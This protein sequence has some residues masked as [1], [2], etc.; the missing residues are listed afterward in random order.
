MT[1]KVIPVVSGEPGGEQHRAVA[2]LRIR[3]ANGAIEDRSF[4]VGRYDIGRTGGHI[5]FAN[6]RTVSRLH[7]QLEVTPGSI[8]VTDLGSTS[9][10]FDTNGARLAGTVSL[11]LHDSVQVGNNVLSVLRLP[12]VLPSSTSGLRGG[13]G[14]QPAIP[15]ALQRG[16]T[17]PAIPAA[18]RNAEQSSS[19]G[20]EANANPSEPAQSGARAK[21]KRSAKSEPPR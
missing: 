6:D 19:A 3:N 17:V 1:K 13:R 16:A 11:G 14:T 9:G 8:L 15:S 5:M 10:T 2:V 4:E 18:L 21:K 12:G 7:A 20:H